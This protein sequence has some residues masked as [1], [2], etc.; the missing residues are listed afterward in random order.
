MA[1]Y[2]WKC[3]VGTSALLLLVLQVLVAQTV[4]A[5]D[6]F[7]ISG[8][9]VVFFGPAQE[10]YDALSEQEQEDMNEI[11]S[12]FYFYQNNVVPFLEANGIKDFH[13]ANPV[14]RVVLSEDESRIFRRGQ[15]EHDVGLIM[16]DGERE[17]VVS[18]GVST[19]VEWIPMFKSY[20]S[21][22]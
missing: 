5:E 4:L 8:K 18:L 10:E 16:I 2:A 9:A 7:D 3:T 13:T 17:P 20:F 19:D 6:S 11:L 14:I 1:F 22:E 15:F 21:I 12:D